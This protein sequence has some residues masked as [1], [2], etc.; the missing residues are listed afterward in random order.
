MYIHFNVCTILNLKNLFPFPFLPQYAIKLANKRNEKRLSAI[1]ELTSTIA[2]AKISN[3]G[4]VEDVGTVELGSNTNGGDA[5]ALDVG[6]S[7]G[8]SNHHNGTGGGTGGMSADVDPE[9]D[10]ASGGISV[11]TPI[12]MAATVTAA[13]D[14]KL[15]TGQSRDRERDWPLSTS[16]NNSI[17]G[18]GSKMGHNHGVTTL[19][20]SNSS[21]TGNSLSGATNNSAGGSALANNINMKQGESG[22]HKNSISGSNRSN[23]N[24][25]P[26]PMAGNLVNNKLSN[27]IH[28]STENYF[29]YVGILE[30]WLFISVDIICKDENF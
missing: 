6:G 18:P 19:I 9:E 11:T 25:H 22:D 28:V 16:I 2:I 15:D 14:V 30:R 29:V 24:H 10:I 17:N 1:S 5:V 23:H 27:S 12:P 8:Q 26:Q 4:L 20:N 7:G 13:P 3:G 21:S